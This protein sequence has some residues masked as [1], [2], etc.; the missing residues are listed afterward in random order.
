MKHRKQLSLH[1]P[2]YVRKNVDG[3]RNLGIYLC[4]RISQRGR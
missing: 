2:L 1:M 4:A 3:C